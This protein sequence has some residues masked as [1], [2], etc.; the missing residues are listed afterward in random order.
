[1]TGLVNLSTFDMTKA[2]IR[3]CDDVTVVPMVRGGEILYRL[4][5]DSQGRFFHLGHA[6]YAFCS[7]LDGKHSI[8]QAVTL[9]ARELKSEAFSEREATR[10]FTWLV[11]NG[12]A[13]PVNEAGLQLSRAT[14]KNKT[15]WSWNPFWTKLPLLQPDH[16]M[17]KLIPI[18]GWLFSP[19]MMLFTCAILV[20]A[21]VILS[22]H[23]ERFLA[24]SEQLF[25]PTN[26][27]WLGLAWLILKVVHE[28]GHG[29]A[30]KYYGGEVRE[31]GII[32]ILFAPMAYVDVTSSWGFNSKWKRMHVAAAGMFVE[33][34]LAGLAVLYW[35]YTDSL[36][37]QHLLY[38]II[39][40]ASISTLIFNANPLMRFDGYY[41]LS[42]LIDIPNMY[43]E[44]NS[45]L[46]SVVGKLCYGEAKSIQHHAGWR[47]VFLLSYG[48]GTFIW[49]IL[50]SLSLT[51][52]ASVLFEGAGIVLAVAGGFL[53]FGM[54]I[55]KTLHNW[56]GQF[57]FKPASAVRAAIL[58]TS[59]VAILLASIFILPC[60]GT[61]QAP[62]IIEYTDLTVVRAKASGFVKTIHV[63]AGQH[64]LEGDLLFEL[65]N[66]T[67][68]VDVADLKA[69][70]QQSLAKQRATRN[71]G[72]IAASQIEVRNQQAM[73][74][75]LQE[76]VE[77]LSGLEIR[78]TSDGLIVG[79]DFQHLIGQYIKVGDEV[80]AIGREHAKE[81]Q[82]S[83]GQEILGIAQETIGKNRSFRLSGTGQLQ[84]KVAHISPRASN[85]APHPAL[86]APYGGVLAVV[87][88]QNRNDEQSERFQLSEPR[89]LVTVELSPEVST[90]TIAGQRGS[91][92]LLFGSRSIAEITYQ[93][94]TKWIRNQLDSAKSHS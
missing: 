75:R 17:V 45:L 72:E 25:A 62:G 31:M 53:W 7:L 26:W 52:T 61:A 60:P 46:K 10:I 59:G 16:L 50:I 44:A 79:K 15:Q 69:S 66:D 56:A 80:L 68:L 70:I 83:I 9:T 65:E 23:W 67:L 81:L 13:V 6:E 49:K 28:F 87:E 47:K 4:R 5:S 74:E 14:H 30:C 42:D 24:S 12:L 22:S 92:Q 82:V 19:A 48:I 1:M 91:L 73:E 40:M 90:K 58:C 8:A 88:K 34:L 54:P 2:K 41:I 94:L 11:D 51:I 32:M 78:A 55:Y 57:Y 63:Q 71:A 39:I 18:L 29:L 3:L 33:L 84:G 76:K 35:A 85:V 38:N 64:I 89:F 20:W 21:G 93:T 77:Q 86:Y 27:L 36:V 43:S 37:V